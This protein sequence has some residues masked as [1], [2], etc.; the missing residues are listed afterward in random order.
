LVFLILVVSFCSL[1]V[2]WVLIRPGPGED[3]RDRQ[4]ADQSKRRAF[5]TI[6]VIMGVLWLRFAG[7]LAAV[8]ISNTKHIPSLCAV[9]SSV[10]WLT[11][12]GSLVLPLLFLHR[13]GK[14]PGCKLS[15]ESG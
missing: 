11:M 7:V 8:L 15:A 5:H 1:S 10:A 4:H 13:A 12:P 14:L 3:G 2:L 9:G 6:T